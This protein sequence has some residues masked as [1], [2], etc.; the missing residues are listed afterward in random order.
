MIKN[1]RADGK[2]LG[3]INAS[4]LLAA[5]ALLDSHAPNPL[6]DFSIL[7]RVVSNRMVILTGQQ[8]GI[9]DIDALLDLAA[10]RP[11]VVGVRDVGSAS[12]FALPITASLL[13][14]DYAV[15]TGYVGSTSRVLAAIR[16]EVDIIIQNYDSV[17]SYVESAELRPLLEIS[18]S[19]PPLPSLGGLQGLAAQVATVRERP[20]EGA[21]EQANALAA[22]MSAG[23]LVVGPAGFPAKLENCLQ[24]SLMDVLMSTEF[25]DAA[26][27][28]NLGVEAVDAAKAKSELASS[29]RSLSDFEQLVRSAVGKSLQ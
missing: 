23:R 16:G 10:S 6:R 2:T 7:A 12:F 24:A 26:A 28:A 4:G 1:A 29:E 17:S 5:N 21:I 11:V 15:V 9:T 14:M 19:R 13:D 27:R 22:I 8:S 25:I 20:V 3:I 18:G